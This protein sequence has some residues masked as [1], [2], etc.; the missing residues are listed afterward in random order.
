M[1]QIK[2][3]LSE[4]HDITEYKYINRYKKNWRKVKKNDEKGICMDNIHKVKTSTK[5]TIQLAAVS[6]FSSKK[7]MIMSNRQ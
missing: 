2:P 6:Y 5:Q 3:R 7:K 4:W 1:E